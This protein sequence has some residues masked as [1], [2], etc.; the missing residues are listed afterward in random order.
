[1]VAKKPTKKLIKGAAKKLSRAVV[2]R[3][4]AKA[5]EP[6]AQNMGISFVCF[7]DAGSKVRDLY[8]YAP[9]HFVDGSHLWMLAHMTWNFRTDKYNIKQAKKDAIERIAMAS[10]AKILANGK[11][12]PGLS[13][14]RCKLVSDQYIK[15]LKIRAGN[16]N[17]CARI[18]HMLISTFSGYRYKT[19][20]QKVVESL[21]LGVFPGVLKNETVTID[22]MKRILPG[23]DLDMLRRL[24]WAYSQEEKKGKAK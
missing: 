14:L 10:S 24:A 19:E 2:K 1:M 15:D 12:T 6:T 8:A 23:P 4:Q 17:R 11:D 5:V 18:V 22:A 21:L 13:K 3:V 7:R 16:N 9:Y 20:A